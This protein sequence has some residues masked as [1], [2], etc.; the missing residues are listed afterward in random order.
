MR[1]CNCSLWCQCAPGPFTAKAMHG[2]HDIDQIA[3]TNACVATST[4]ISIPT[5]IIA[6]I[7][8]RV[9]ITGIISTSARARYLVKLSY[10]H[11]MNVYTCTACAAALA[12]A[13][14]DVTVAIDRD[15]D[16]CIPAAVHLRL[17]DR[18]IEHDHL[19]A[20]VHVHVHKNR[21]CACACMLLSSDYNYCSRGV[22]LQYSEAGS[23]SLNLMMLCF[24]RPPAA[25][26][27]RN[28]RNRRACHPSQLT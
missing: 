11:N 25:S 5:L 23:V 17:T 10:V 4:L 26:R 28:S 9:R 3:G 27:H 22:L 12:L 18:D 14:H 19:H 8:L 21:T 16:R 1:S 24:R 15:I 7:R 20:R 6:D 2:E 13:D